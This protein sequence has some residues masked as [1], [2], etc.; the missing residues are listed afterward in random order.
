MAKSFPDSRTPLRFPAAM[1]MVK[2]TA[3][4]TCSG[5]RPEKAEVRASVPAATDTATVST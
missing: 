4:H 2:A 3:I 1:A 5:A